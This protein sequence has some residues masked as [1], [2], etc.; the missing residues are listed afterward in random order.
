MIYV[1]KNLEKN[2][3]STHTEIILRT[4]KIYWSVMIHYYFC[5]NFILF[6]IKKRFF[7]K[8][9]SSCGTVAIMT[10]FTIKEVWI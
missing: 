10:F 1:V 4:K 2:R 5:F 3:K 9:L 6:L 7:S 8:F